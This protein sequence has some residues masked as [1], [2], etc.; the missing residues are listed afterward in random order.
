MIVYLVGDEAHF[1]SHPSLPGKTFGHWV[2]R[3]SK[4]M[5]NTRSVKQKCIQQVLVH[6]CA[7]EIFML[8]DR[9]IKM[10]VINSSPLPEKTQHSNQSL[11]VLIISHTLTCYLCTSLTS[12]VLQHV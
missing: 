2:A 10:H 12:S 6:L 7:L 9:E 11:S 1:H 5:A 4:S 3:Q 8:Q